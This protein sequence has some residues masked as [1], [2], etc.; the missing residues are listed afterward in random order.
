MFKLDLEKAEEPEVKLTTSFGS[1]EKQGNP[2]RKA[3]KQTNKNYFCFTFYAKVFDCV[4]ENKL[5]KILQEM[6]TPDRLSCL[7]RNLCAGQG[8][9]LSPCLFN[10]YAEYILRN[11]RL[12]EAQARIKIGRRNINN[13]RYADDTTFMTESEEELKSFKM[14]MKE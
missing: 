6:R 4:D 3:N 12:D 1:S 7:L 5:W 8:C 14:K 10:L 13:L 2:K 9:T 11:S